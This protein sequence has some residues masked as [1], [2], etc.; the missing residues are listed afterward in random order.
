MCCT[1]SVID[2][3][4]VFK[5][6]KLRH[7]VYFALLDVP[8]DIR[9]VIGKTRLSKTLETSDPKLAEIRHHKQLSVWKDEIRLARLRL[10]EYLAKANL[11]AKTDAKVDP[12]EV[13]QVLDTLGE[14]A[15]KQ[16]Q[17]IATKQD[18][19][20]SLNVR[21]FISQLDQVQLSKDQVE[22]DLEMI[23]LRF[24]NFSDVTTK[25][26]RKWIKD[27]R[28]DRTDNAI[29][30]VLRSFKK[31]I[32]YISYKFDVECSA[33]FTVPR[34]DK[35]QSVKANRTII[36]PDQA[37]KLY[38]AADDRLK[39]FIVIGA[40]TGMRISEIGKLKVKHIIFD[41][42]VRCI[43]I[44]AEVKTD[45][46]IRRF[47]I[48]SVLISVFDDLCKEKSDNDYLFDLPRTG[49]R[50][51]QVA[52][53]DFS[54]LK[55]K[56]GYGLEITFHG[57]RHSVETQLLRGGVDA[58]M[59]DQIIGHKTRGNSEG[60]KTYWHGYELIAMKKA[61]ELISWPKL[62]TSYSLPFEDDPT[63]D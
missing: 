10:P 56:L 4:H 21:D 30:R 34:F 16:F 43:D 59:I 36:N 62:A 5:M 15:A 20:L 35:V 11:L 45:Y 51:S 2:T 13:K 63:D 49:K 12:V 58:K 61:V 27:S 31:F 60:V 25:N 44:D 33:D 18:V 40:Y 19:V 48:H 17:T 26:V 3:D 54:S 9:D 24:P 37:L 29:A 41:Q 38:L 53:N 55:T 22:R 28:Q 1:V 47:P 6:L 42:K 46:S 32:A 8:A 14:D 52:G 23:I 39:N 7:R 57:F 50:H